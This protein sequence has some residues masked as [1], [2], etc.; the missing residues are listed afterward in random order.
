MVLRLQSYSWYSH[1][2]RVKIKDGICS[3]QFTPQRGFLP[4]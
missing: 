4:Y 2:C 3:Y 1:S